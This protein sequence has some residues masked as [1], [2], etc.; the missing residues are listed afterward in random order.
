MSK[1]FFFFVAKLNYIK[2]FMLMGH[3]LQFTSCLISKMELACWQALRGVLA[4]GRKRNPPPESSWKLASR[5]KW[6]NQFQWSFLFQAA[7]SWLLCPKD[8]AYFQS[9]F[10]LFAT[11]KAIEVCP[12]VDKSLFIMVILKR[13]LQKQ[14]SSLRP[15]CLVSFTFLF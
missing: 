3:L 7:W 12:Y 1:I 10:T 2:L 13:T 11:I 5:L 8:S 14:I 6:N 4:M 15:N 9:C